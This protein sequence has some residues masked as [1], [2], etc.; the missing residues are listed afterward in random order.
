MKMSG[1]LLKCKQWVDTKGGD[2]VDP[3]NASLN[4]EINFN[5]IIIP[6]TP[7]DFLKNTMSYPKRKKYRP[8]TY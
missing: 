3:R 6:L 5:L 1:V 8:L 4:Q 7:A 2:E